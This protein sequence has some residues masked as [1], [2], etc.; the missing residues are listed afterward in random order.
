MLF[1]NS[2]LMVIELFVI[3]LLSNN[4]ILCNKSCL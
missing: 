3:M 4:S 1:A 2:T